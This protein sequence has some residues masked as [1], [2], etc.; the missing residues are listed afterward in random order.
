MMKRNRKVA[1]V[2]AALVPPSVLLGVLMLVSDNPL[3]PPYCPEG[4]THQEGNLITRIQPQCVGGLLGSPFVV[5]LLVI[6]GVTG[7]AIAWRR[8]RKRESVE[9]YN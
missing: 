1:V 2:L 7:A 8:V 9:A 6:V 5:A 3:F 4:V